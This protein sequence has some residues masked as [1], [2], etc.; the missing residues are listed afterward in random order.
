MERL[1]GHLPLL[2]IWLAICLVLVLVT[3]SRIASGMG[4]DPDDHLRMVQLRDWLGGQSWFDTTQYRIGE[5]ESQPMH[6]P[7]CLA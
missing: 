6:W 4:W 3:K 7:R 2:L 1:R 5:P